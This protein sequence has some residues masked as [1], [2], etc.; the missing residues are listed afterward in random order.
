MPADELRMFCRRLNSEGYLDNFSENLG[1]S[2]IAS[3]STTGRHWQDYRVAVI[4]KFILESVFTPIAVAFITTL[5][6]LWLRL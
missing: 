2:F 1:G 4:K 5:I 6:T 3:L